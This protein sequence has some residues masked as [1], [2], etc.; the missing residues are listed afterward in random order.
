MPPPHLLVFAC[1][2]CM[3]ILL[4]GWESYTSWWDN[5]NLS[6]RLDGVYT[7]PWVRSMGDFVSKCITLLWKRHELWD[8]PET[9]KSSGTNVWEQ[10]PSACKRNNSLSMLCSEARVSHSAVS[11]KGCSLVET[12]FRDVI[13]NKQSIGQVGLKIIIYRVTVCMLFLARLAYDWNQN[14]MIDLSKRWQLRW[15]CTMLYVKSWETWE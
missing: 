15:F 3:I 1:Q 7:W 6:C 13:F 12:R 9:H 11:W 5:G 2:K 14:I 4:I 8:F 10:A